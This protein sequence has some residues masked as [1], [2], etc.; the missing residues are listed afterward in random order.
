MKKSSLLLLIV[1]LAISFTLPAEE[2]PQVDFIFLV[3]TSL[4]MAPAIGDLKQYLAGGIVGPFVQPGDWVA[5]LAFYGK[6]NLIWEGEIRTEADKAALIRSLHALEA[7]GRFTDIGA[8]L[9]AMTQLVTQRNKP[10]I[11]KYILLLTD[12]VQEA[13]PGSA[14]QS[15]DFTIHH[16]LLEYVRRVDRGSFLAI[17]VG[18]GLASRIESNLATLMRTLNE[19]PVRPE[20]PLPGDSTVPRQDP[21]RTGI[22]ISDSSGAGTSQGT[23]SITSKSEGEPALPGTPGAEGARSPASGSQ[24][25][26]TSQAAAGAGESSRGLNYSVIILSL[27]AAGLVLILLILIRSRKGKNSKSIKAGSKKEEEENGLSGSKDGH[28]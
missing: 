5:V 24:L 26:G 17:T 18:Y 28:R 12:E 22:D 13:P 25:E 3:D 1:L 27:G 2:G 20:R 9:D 23:Q 7:T 11:P 8:A 21:A 19:P 4:S 16:E 10:D 15:D 6:T 14:Y